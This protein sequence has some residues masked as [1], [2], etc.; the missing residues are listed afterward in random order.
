MK[1]T[2]AAKVFNSLVQISVG[3]GSKV[4]FWTDRWLAGRA[5]GDFAPTVLA[6]VNIQ[7]RNRR[8]VKEALLNHTWIND[9][10]VGLGMQGC[11][12]CLPVLAMVGSVTIV[13]DVPDTFR[14]P[15]SGDGLYSAQ[16]TYKLL[17]QGDVRF[18]GLFVFGRAG[19]RSSAKFSHGW[20]GKAG[21]G[22]RTGA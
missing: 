6:L 16:S 18:S 3:D 13:E 10:G 5:I 11:L 8:S 22:L 17:C 20:P 2:Q 9:V 21:C 4:L 7:R 19:L 15:W 14:W 12:E 1:D